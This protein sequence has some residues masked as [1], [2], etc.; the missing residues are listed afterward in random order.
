M[1]GVSPSCL[2][3]CSLGF[4]HLLWQPGFTSIGPVLTYQWYISSIFMGTL[5]AP[6]LAAKTTISWILSQSG[7]RLIFNNHKKIFIL[8]SIRFSILN[9]DYLHV[10]YKNKKELYEISKLKRL[11]FI[12]KPGLCAR[13]VLRLPRKVGQ[14]DWTQ[15]TSLSKVTMTMTMTMKYALQGDRV[16]G[17]P[18]SQRWVHSQV[19]PGEGRRVSWSFLWNLVVHSEIIKA[20]ID[21]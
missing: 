9:Q 18:G 16:N 2:M 21:L 13:D 10:M 15:R 3:G 20:S 4:Y 11:S 12:L 14:E 17:R 5:I 8:F 1:M 7:V 19:P 6:D